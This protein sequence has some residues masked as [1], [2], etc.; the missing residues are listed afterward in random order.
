MALKDLL[1]LRAGDYLL[2]RTG[3]R[4]IL[5]E[6]KAAAGFD[7]KIISELRKTVTVNS[8][9]EKDVLVVTSR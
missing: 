7:V 6:A 3:D 1:L 9:L 4:L 5:R 8:L 2:L